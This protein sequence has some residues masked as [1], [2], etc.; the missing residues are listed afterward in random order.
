MG[1]RIAELLDHATLQWFRDFCDAGYSTTGI[2]GLQD[3]WIDLLCRLP[4]TFESW[5]AR[6]FLDWGKYL[7]PDL[8]A[9]LMD[10]EAERII[11]EE[12]ADLAFQL[13]EYQLEARIGRLHGHIRR[14]LADPPADQPHRPVRPALLPGRARAK[15]HHA[16][17]RLFADQEHWH[18]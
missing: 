9:S 2:E 12:F 8:L 6:T 5:I 15:P 17:P 14:L 18:Q 1:T 11:D 4:S 3:R 16:V 13:D 10:G 7:M